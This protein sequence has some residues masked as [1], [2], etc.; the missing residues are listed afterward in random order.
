MLVDLESASRTLR[1]AKKRASTEA[2]RR[3]AAAYHS[4]DAM[5]STFI[6]VIR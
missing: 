2:G 6:S 4:Q 3:I 1:R 5:D